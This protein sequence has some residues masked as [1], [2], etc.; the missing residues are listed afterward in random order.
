MSPDP[1]CDHMTDLRLHPPA[2]HLTEEL[3]WRFRAVP[4]EHPESWYPRSDWAAITSRWR[5][6]SATASASSMRR[7][8]PVSRSWTTRGSITTE[9]QNKSWGR[10]W[11]DA[12]N[13]CS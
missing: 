6:Q 13:R 1:F 9:N 2:G 5:N 7:S 3:E 12:V 11:L 10:R 8:T 4:L